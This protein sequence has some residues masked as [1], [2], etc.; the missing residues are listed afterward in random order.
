MRAGLGAVPGRA[1]KGACL[2]ARPI[3]L[4]RL[5]GG[6]LLLGTKHEARQRTLDDSGRHGAANDLRVQRNTQRSPSRLAA[7]H[8]CS[9]IRQPHAPAAPF[10]RRTPTM[11]EF[12]PDNLHDTRS[13]AVPPPCAELPRAL[14]QAA[15]LPRAQ[16]PQR[17][18]PSLAFRLRRAPL[19]HAPR[20]PLPR[21]RAARRPLAPPPPLPA[22]PRPRTEPPTPLP[23]CRR[24]WAQR[25]RGQRWSWRRARLR[26]KRRRLRRRWRQWRHSA[27][28]RAI[29]VCGAAGLR[30]PAY[31]VRGR[32]AAWRRRQT[33]SCCRAARVAG[34]AV[35]GKAAARRRWRRAARLLTPRVM[36]CSAALVRRR[37]AML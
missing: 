27:A 10:G 11:C 9:A 16:P 33:T 31:H 1:L 15:T 2:L 14:P 8:P 32:A 28:A 13:E 25:R 23:W 26:W 29:S 6:T 34:M 36:G 20:P 21:E 17:P 18:L 35:W 22:P 19:P 3:A 24:P 30:R 4:A 12:E 7:A 5:D 37:R